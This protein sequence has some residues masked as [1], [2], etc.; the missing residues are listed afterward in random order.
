M[1]IEQQL[2]SSTMFGGTL[3]FISTDEKTFRRSHRTESCEA[4]DT[5]TASV[6]LQFVIQPHSFVTTSSR[7]RRTRVTAVQAA[8]SDAATLAGKSSVPS[9]EPVAS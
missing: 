3:I 1:W 8:T 6:N 4:C 5:V 2:T 9:E 7:F